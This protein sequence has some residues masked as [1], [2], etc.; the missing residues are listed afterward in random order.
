MLLA[1]RIPEKLIYLLRLLIPPGDW[2]AY[3]YDR[4]DRATLRRRRLVHAPKFILKG[5]GGLRETAS[6]GVLR[7]LVHAAING[8]I[9]ADGQQPMKSTE[10]HKLLDLA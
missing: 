3:Y 7:Q 2:L 6:R 4:H 5:L 10:A 9:N 1:S 8:R